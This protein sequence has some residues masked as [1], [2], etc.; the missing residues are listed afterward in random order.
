MLYGDEI[1]PKEKDKYVVLE[2]YRK[3]TTPS[4][5]KQI[6]IGSLK[7]SVPPQLR[8]AAAAASSSSKK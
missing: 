3:I 1:D 4:A 5:I 8:A 7:I 2:F 6:L